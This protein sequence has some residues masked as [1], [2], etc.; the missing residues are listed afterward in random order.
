MIQQG[1][2]QLINLTLT[3][4]RRASSNYGNNIITMQNDITLR[5]IAQRRALGVNMTELA[6]MPA[7]SQDKR[8]I[9]DYE[10]GRRKPAQ[11]YIDS[12]QGLSAFYQL[13]L[14]TLSNDIKA[15]RLL[16]SDLMLPYFSEIA[17]FERVTGNDCETYWRL[18]QA[19]VGHLALTGDIISLNDDAPIPA[20]FKQTL[21]L[22]NKGY[23][24]TNKDKVVL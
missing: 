23:E 17:D 22:L 4:A 20:S 9:A 14:S 2:I 5:L 10:R 7:V 13:L 11:S 3:L 6:D 24:T 16:S 1:V 15:H 18:W 12:I 8:V 19:V 21:F